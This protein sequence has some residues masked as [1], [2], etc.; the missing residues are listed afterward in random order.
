MRAVV[1]RSFGGPSRIE[2]VETPTPRPAP[3]EVLVRVAAAP[4]HPTDLMS[5]AGLYVEFGAAVAADQYGVGSTSPA[6]S[7][8]SGTTCRRSR[9]GRR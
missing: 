2:V 8:R 5:A 7:T 6:W 9:R 3:H 1:V 4:L